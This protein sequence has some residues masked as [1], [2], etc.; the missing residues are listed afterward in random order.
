MGVDHLWTSH[1]EIVD[2]LMEKFIAPVRRVE[3]TNATH[4]PSYLTT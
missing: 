3:I 4:W 1:L 2:A